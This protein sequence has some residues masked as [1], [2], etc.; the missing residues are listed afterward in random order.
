MADFFGQVI[1]DIVKYWHMVNRALKQRVQTT[2]FA[3]FLIFAQTDQYVP[4]AQKLFLKAGKE[5]E[6]QLVEEIVSRCENHPMYVQQFLF[7][8]WE[9][10]VTEFSMM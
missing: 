2:P 6:A 1:G 4:W 3:E 9:E 10:K 5:I 7:Y 8:L